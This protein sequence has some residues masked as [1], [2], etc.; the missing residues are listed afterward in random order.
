M[1][2]YKSL[3]QKVL[4]QWKVLIPMI[5]QMLI[6]M[7]FALFLSLGLCGRQ[8]KDLV[9]V[10]KQESSSTFLWVWE[11]QVWGVKDLW[12]AGRVSSKAFLGSHPG[13]KLWQTQD[14][15]VPL[16][17]DKPAINGTNPLLKFACIISSA[18]LL[19]ELGIIL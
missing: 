6:K 19:M 12:H 16:Q 8:L 1:D 14:W 13:C 4:C 15:Q 3:E 17:E 18:L 2:V 11:R 9:F 7:R 5:I 10:G